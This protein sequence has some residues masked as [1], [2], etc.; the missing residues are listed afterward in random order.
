MRS[1][2]VVVPIGVGLV[3][4]VA[5]A[6]AGSGWLTGLAVAFGL[7]AYTMMALNLFLAL[8]RPIVERVVGPLDRAYLLHRALGVSVVG[9]VGVHLMLAPV[10]SF[11]DRGLSILEQPAPPL[12]A[13]ALGLV[14]LVGSVALAMNARVPYDRWQR[15]HMATAGA[16]VV[17]TAH[18]L[19]ALGS[20]G[21]LDGP[22]PVLLALVAAGG[23]VSLAIRIADKVRGGVPYRV[24]ALRP[25]ERYVE[26][27][28]RPAGER[29]LRAHSPGQFAFVTA[30][31]GSRETHPF[32][33]TSAPGDEEVSAL[34]RSAGDWTSRVPLSVRVGDAVLLQGPF[35]GFRPG[36]VDQ[37]RPQVWIAG[38]SGITPFLSVVRSWPADREAT[39]DLVFAARSRSDAPAWEELVTAAETRPWLRLRPHFS[40]ESGHLDDAAMKELAAS[41]PQDAIWFLCGPVSLVEAVRRT[42]VSAGKKERDIHHERYSWRPGSN[43]AKRT[44]EQGR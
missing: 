21:L 34:I 16:F 5:V 36:S 28:L 37:A 1:R 14:L 22:V 6:V 15:V 32:T 17:L 43:L 10:A 19:V 42:L 13:G 8:R 29:R 26:L 41:A 18:G 3:A 12:I 7:A 24:E 25:A 31:A 2:I 9:L 11:V 27:V 33:I 44:Q 40:S 4:L 30:D 35:G 20:W 23:V 39:V 38:G